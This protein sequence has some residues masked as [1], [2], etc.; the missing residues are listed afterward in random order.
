MIFDIIHKTTN[1]IRRGQ[2]DLEY[3]NFV[4]KDG[5]VGWDEYHHWKP[6]EKPVIV[7]KTT[8]FDTILSIHNPILFVDIEITLKTGKKTVVTIP[9]ES[10]RHTKNHIE[11]KPLIGRLLFWKCTFHGSIPKRKEKVYQLP[12]G[13]SYQEM[14]DRFARIRHLVCDVC[15]GIDQHMCHKCSK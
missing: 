11:F 12:I 10:D 1:E 5:N 13:R 2:W 14:I 7:A 9:L 15:L 4:S 8:K 3:L 6:Y